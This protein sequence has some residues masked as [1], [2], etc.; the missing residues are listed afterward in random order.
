MASYGRSAE[1]NL[2]VM[3]IGPSCARHTPEHS[4]AKLET[5]RAGWHE[6][7]TEAAVF[8]P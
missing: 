5:A 7:E 4:F 6:R 3:L 8:C 2:G 1:E